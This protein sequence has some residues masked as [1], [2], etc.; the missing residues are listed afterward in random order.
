MARRESKERRESEFTTTGIE[1]KDNLREARREERMERREERRDM[2]PRHDLREGERK[3]AMKKSS[4]KGF[5][6]EPFM[7]NGKGMCSYNGNPMPPALRTSRQCGPG[8]NEDQRK[9]NM[10]LQKAHEKWDSQ[11]G[12]SGM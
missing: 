6:G 1:R 5:G 2:T 8:L 7:N 10:L 4:G 11:R 9:A 12:K 3:E